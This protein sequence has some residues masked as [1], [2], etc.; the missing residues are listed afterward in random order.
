MIDILFSIC[1]DATAEIFLRISDYEIV[2]QKYLQ[3]LQL[4][5]RGFMKKKERN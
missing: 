4:L 3:K 5:R 1:R 2:K